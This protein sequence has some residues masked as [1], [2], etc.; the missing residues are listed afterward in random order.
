MTEGT[1]NKAREKFIGK[2]RAASTAWYLADTCMSSAIPKL[3]LLAF[4]GRLHCIGMID[5][6]IVH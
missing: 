3:I 5:D 1:V 6:V 2:K 4:T